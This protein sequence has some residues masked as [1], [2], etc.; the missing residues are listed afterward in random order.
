VPAAELAADPLVCD[1]GTDVPHPPSSHHIFFTALAAIR[2]GMEASIERLKAPELG[3][4][5]L[6]P[7]LVDMETIQCVR[8]KFQIQ[9]HMVNVEVENFDNG[10]QIPARRGS[11][12]NE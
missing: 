4:R 12:G 3:E 6:C 11:G 8:T 9:P 2:R 10:L 7:Q 1:G 5:I